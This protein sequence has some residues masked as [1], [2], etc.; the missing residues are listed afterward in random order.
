MNG[1]WAQYT[2]EL[3][4]DI[5]RGELE[6]ELSNEGLP[7]MTRYPKPMHEQL[8]FK[9]GSICIDGCPVTRHLCSA[10]LS[11]PIGPYMTEEDVD[12]VSQT[13]E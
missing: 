3:P 11:H 1:S 4:S 10:V 7:M 2:I 6:R 13:A 12:A 8:A 9:G 5:D